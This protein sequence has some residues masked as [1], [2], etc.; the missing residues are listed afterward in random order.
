MLVAVFR[1]MEDGT[2]TAA[3][4]QAMGHAALLAPVLDIVPTGAPVPGGAF[5]GIVFTSAHG[6][7]ALGPAASAGLGRV[8]CF[9]VGDRTAEL[10]AS[11]GFRDLR[12][13][14]ADAER[15]AR[16][17]CAAVHPPGRVLLVAGRDRKAAI[18]QRLGEAGYDVVVIEAYE[19]RAVESWPKEACDVLRAG[20]VAA[21]LHYSRRSADLAAQCASASGVVEQVLATHHV[22]L[23]EDAALPLRRA[24]AARVVIAA[25]PNETSLL[26]A[27]A[28]ATDGG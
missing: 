19:A 14:R 5:E 26:A 2:R 25:E 23:S 4:L 18:E 11:A 13:G 10:A 3:K 22:C 12:V 28:S 8:P 21:A 27:L 6:V 20:R 15:L 17:V 1:A 24:G 16:L 7:A 9:C